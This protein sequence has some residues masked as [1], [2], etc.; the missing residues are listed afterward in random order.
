[1][2]NDPNIEPPF[3]WKFVDDIT[4]SEIIE[5]ENVSNVQSL[6]NG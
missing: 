4:T 1:M 3:L 6:I 5:K 2:I